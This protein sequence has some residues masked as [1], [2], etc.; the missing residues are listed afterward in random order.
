MAFFVTFFVSLI[1]LLIGGREKIQCDLSSW[2][3]YAFAFICNDMQ[4]DIITSINKVLYY[5][6]MYD[7]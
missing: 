7:L 2:Q 1:L 3:S 6:Y 5:F 4:V